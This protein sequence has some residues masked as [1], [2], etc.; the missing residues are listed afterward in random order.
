MATLPI[1]PLAGPRFVLDGQ[2]AGH[3]VHATAMTEAWD[4]FVGRLEHALGRFD[5]EGARRLAYELTGRIHQGEVLPATTAAYILGKLRRKRFFE[6]I[7]QLGETFR[8][9]LPFGFG[10]SMQAVRGQD[11]V[12]QV[13]AIVA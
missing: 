3:G 5:R 1:D 11:L 8:F 6:L 13:K 7:E 12:D 4:D 9:G 2:K 10:R